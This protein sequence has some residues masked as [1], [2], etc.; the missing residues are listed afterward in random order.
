[1]QKAGADWEKIRAEFLSGTSAAEISRQFGVPASTVRQ[2]ARRGGWKQAREE[3][4]Q[5]ARDEFRRQ[6]TAATQSVAEKLAAAES[7]ALDDLIGMMAV[8]EP[9]WARSVGT[10]D[11][12]ALSRIVASI[13]ALHEILI[14]QEQ[15]TVRIEVGERIR[16]LGE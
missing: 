4:E 1:M 5:E 11:V 2:R 16:E 7:R 8:L 14:P 6:V 3:I 12:M 10:D 9:Q 13:K 15:Q